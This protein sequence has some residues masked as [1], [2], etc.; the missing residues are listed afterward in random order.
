MNISPWIYF[1]IKHGRQIADLIATSD[2]SSNHNRLLEL[3]HVIAPWLKKW[4]PWTNDNSLLD[5]A[6]DALE[7]SITNTQTITH[8]PGYPDPTQS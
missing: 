3:T 7:N 8:W 1:G 5:D 6:L 2:L 4:F